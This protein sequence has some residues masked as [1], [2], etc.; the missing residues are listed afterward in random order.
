[1]VLTGEAFYHRYYMYAYFRNEYQAIHD[2]VDELMNCE[3]IAMNFLIS[4]LTRKPPIKGA[5][6]LR[7]RDLSP[8]SSTIF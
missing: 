3:D 4:H 7:S 6:F 1:M 2:K 8:L 5:V